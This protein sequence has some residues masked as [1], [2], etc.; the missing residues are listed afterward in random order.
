M[1]GLERT[2]Y[3]MNEGSVVDIM[4]IVIEGEITDNIVVTLSTDDGTAT[5]KWSL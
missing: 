1:I 3:T 2:E 4:I 5:S